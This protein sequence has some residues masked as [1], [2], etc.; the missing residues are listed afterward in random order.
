VELLILGDLKMR[1]KMVYL[2]AVIVF[3]ATI[4]GGAAVYSHC[5]IPCGI[6]GDKGRFELMDEHIRTI[7]LSID[8]INELSAA[9]KPD[10]NQIVR[11]VNNKEHHADEL[12]EIV[13]WYFMSQRI[14]PVEESHDQYKQY[15]SKLTKLH[16]MLVYSMKAKQSAE[17]ANADKLHSLFG[18]FEAEYFAK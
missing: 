9:Q 12:S 1:R 6:Y 15:V 14:K 7:S 4:F 13:T 8:K 17:Q 5:Q 2:V 18:L 10:N 11:W 3:I 16:E